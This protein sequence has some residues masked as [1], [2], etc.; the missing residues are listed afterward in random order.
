MPP[1]RLREILAALLAS[2]PHVELLPLADDAARAMEQFGHSRPSVV[3]LD[4]EL[5]GS[6]AL[7][8]LRSLKSDDPGVRCVVLVN[9]YKAELLA[10]SAQA[11][12]VLYKGFS[13]QDLMGLMARYWNERPAV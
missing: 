2:L 13:V 12:A 10:R 5:A 1:S 4:Y 9:S 3:L 6:A 8:A 7:S 11:D